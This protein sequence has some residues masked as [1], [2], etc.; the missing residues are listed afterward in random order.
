MSV[1]TKPL[2]RRRVSRKLRRLISLNVRLNRRI[3][4]NPT[5]L[6]PTKP[7]SSLVSI[8]GTSV[9]SG[10]VCVDD[11]EVAKVLNP[12]VDLRRNS[13]LEVY[14]VKNHIMCH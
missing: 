1:R 6:Y 10:G 11:G 2:I 9:V 7:S 5:Y 14:D 12:I 3:E 13:R 8:V 4:D